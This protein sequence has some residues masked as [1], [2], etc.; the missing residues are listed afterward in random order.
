M[1]RTLNAA[2]SIAEINDATDS[3]IWPPTAN[4]ALF[5]QIL[6]DIL[7]YGPQIAALILQIMPLFSL[8]IALSLP[9]LDLA[10]A[11]QPPPVPTAGIHLD[12]KSN[13]ARKLG[14][15]PLKPGVYDRLR[16]QVRRPDAPPAPPP[17]V[18]LNDQS[19]IS[20][21]VLD[22]NGFNACA[23]AAG[24]LAHRQAEIVAGNPDPHDSVAD[25]YDPCN[26]GQ[27]EGAD[28]STCANQLTS[29]GVAPDSLVPD[30]E[31]PIES[32]RPGL[33]KARAA[34]KLQSSTFLPDDQ[35]LLAALERGQPVYFGILV[36]NRFDPDQSGYIAPYGGLVEGG[37]AV[38]GLG[39][40][41]HGT[42]WDILMRNSWGTSW[43]GAVGAAH[44]AGACWLDHTWAQP[45]IYGAFAFAAS[46]ATAAPAPLPPLCVT[47]Q[48]PF[49]APDINLP[50]ASLPSLWD[51]NITI[52]T[53]VGARQFS[54]ARRTPL[55]TLVRKLLRR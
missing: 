14:L 41:P 24:T 6:E 27:D 9:A 25:L 44:P 17:V 55:R 1:S 50:A 22:Q 46:P 53:R 37:H 26:G 10:A 36:T 23:A 13:A 11:D 20:P 42:S 48:C 54:A 4:G 43:G 30:W 35:S 52:N 39:V 49:P 16:A 40:R 47:G 3:P 34:N 15:K 45:K 18:T 12:V 38:V 19:A 31:I 21:P 5:Q 2:K 32:P 29:T 8:L 33:A 7:E 51:W 28:L